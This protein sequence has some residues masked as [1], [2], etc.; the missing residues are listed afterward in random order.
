MSPRKLLHLYDRHQL[1]SHGKKHNPEW[2]HAS[3]PR[4]PLTETYG[5]M[6]LICRS[7]SN[8][9]HSFFYFSW[10]LWNCM[11]VNYIRNCLVFYW[12]PAAQLANPQL[13]DHVYVVTVIWTNGWNIIS[14]RQIKSESYWDR[15]DIKL[16]IHKRF[17]NEHQLKCVKGA[18]QICKIY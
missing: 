18:S 5:R 9:L 4:Y 1:Y 13:F 11:L 3:Y 15:N 16:M 6:F 17:V 7:K 8:R 10:Y 14:V 2:V 12:C